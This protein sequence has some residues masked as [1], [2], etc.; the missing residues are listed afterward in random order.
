[1]SRPKS[2]DREKLLDAAERLVAAK[3]AA[4]LTFG[5]LARELGI[6][7]GG[8]QYSFPSKEALIDALFERWSASYE[9]LL[10]AAAG[11]SPG[12]PR[13]AWAHVQATAGS[14]ENLNAKMAG[15]TGAILQTPEHLAS[16]RA[17]YRARV[18]GLELA[19]EEGRRARLA[20]LAAEGAF[21]L[22]YFNLME[23]G[24]QDWADI[25]RDIHE[26]LGPPP[27][28]P[29]ETDS[30]RIDKISEAARGTLAAKD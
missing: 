22:R 26:I 14:D 6:T 10:R 5:A 23:I 8:V 18:E 16:T 30:K 1:M 13:L 27:P 7:K 17:W 28:A 11:E 4:G 24:P 3:G 9:G 15:L 21:A 29:V 25:F 19:T 12:Q 20:F 2:I